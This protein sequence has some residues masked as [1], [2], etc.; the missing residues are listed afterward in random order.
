MLLDSVVVAQ[1]SETLVAGNRASQ[2]LDMDV[3]SDESPTTRL[4]ALMPHI[5][6]VKPRQDVR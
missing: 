5:V 3:F 6:S 4:A 1:G 2:E